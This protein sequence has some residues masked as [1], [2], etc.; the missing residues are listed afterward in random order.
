MSLP[1]GFRVKTF[2]P[3]LDRG[4][5]HGRLSSAQYFFNMVDRLRGLLYNLPNTKQKLRVSAG[6]DK[7][8][9]AEGA[10]KP[11]AKM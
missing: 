9:S 5:S 6:G 4:V 7:T 2:P 8:L 3:A 11:G 1:K 10:S